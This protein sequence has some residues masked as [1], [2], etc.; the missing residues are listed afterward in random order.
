MS[1]TGNSARLVTDVGAVGGLIASPA[2]Q[3]IGASIA[4]AA[5]LFLLV[6]AASFWSFRQVEEAAAAR[7]HSSLVI[8][9]AG[10][11]LANLTDAETGQRGYSLTGDTAFLEPYLAVSDHISESLVQLRQLGLSGPAQ[12]KLDALSLIHI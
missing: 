1:A 5:L 11:W 4:A 10:D 6:V 3:K 12:R 9:S 7:Q 2:T 8:R